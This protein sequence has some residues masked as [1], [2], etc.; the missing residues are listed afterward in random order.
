MNSPFSY[1]WNAAAAGQDRRRR[2]KPPSI[3]ISVAKRTIGTPWRFA[4]SALS[5]C[6]RLCASCQYDNVR[7]EFRDT[8]EDYVSD[9]P[10]AAG[11]GNILLAYDDARILH[12]LFVA[13]ADA[14]PHA[15]LAG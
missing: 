15:V 14:L 2:A 5:G 4:A 13:D 11:A 3:S 8:L 12:S 10:K 7:R 1:A 6:S 9:L